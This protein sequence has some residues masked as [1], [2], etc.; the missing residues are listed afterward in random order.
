MGRAGD[1]LSGGSDLGGQSIL[2]WGLAQLERHCL[3]KMQGLMVPMVGVCVCVCALV[4]SGQ[5]LSFWSRLLPAFVAV[6]AVAAGG[7]NGRDDIF[8][9]S[10]TL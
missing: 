7:N 2:K 3:I 10:M 6:S 5:G 4:E 8:G 1:G 9:C